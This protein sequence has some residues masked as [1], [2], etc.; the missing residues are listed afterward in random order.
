MLLYTLLPYASSNSIVSVPVPPAIAVGGTTILACLVSP[1]LPQANWS[2]CISVALSVKAGGV[3]TLTTVSVL[4]PLS[5]FITVIVYTPASK[6]LAERVP[7]F[8]L[9]AV[10]APKG[11]TIL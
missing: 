1:L 8:H 5:L 6:S 2:T 10:T 9:G 11:P 3:P 4:Q 7:K